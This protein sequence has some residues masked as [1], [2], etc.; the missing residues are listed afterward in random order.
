MGA[1][2]FEP[3]GDARLSTGRII[4]ALVVWR[5][6]L[7]VLLFF[8]RRFLLSLGG[9]AFDRV[10]HDLAG[11]GIDI[12]LMDAVRHLDVEGIDQASLF[13][14]KLAFRHC[15]SFLGQGHLSGLF[16]SD[17]RLFA[18]FGLAGLALIGAPS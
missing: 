1:S 13:M 12:D 5:R 9:S 18:Q 4:A 11:L 2:P 7:L 16:H 8:I 6:A 10:F 17:L 15:S 14:Y 3:G